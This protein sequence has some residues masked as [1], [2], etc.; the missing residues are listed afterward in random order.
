MAGLSAGRVLSDFFDHVTVVD[1]DAYPEGALERPGVPQSRHVHALLARG[2]QELDGLFPGFSEAMRAGGAH[3]LD[4]PSAFATL[5]PTGWAPRA[6]NRLP[7]FFASRTQIETTVR[8]LFRKLPNVTLLERTAV[9]GL[10]ATRQGHTKATG[11]HITPLDGGVSTT[12]ETDLIVDASGRASKAP[13]WF[14]ELGLTPP[15]ETI[16]DSF[17]GYSSRW[18]KAPDPSRL[19]R[20]WWW[21]GVWIDVKLP[22]NTFACVLIPVEQGRWLVTIAGVAK[23]YPPND[24]AGF[25]ATLPQLRSPIIDKMVQ[26]AEPISPVYS[27]RAMANRFRHYERWQER[28]D[29]FLALGD[30]ACAF[31]PVYGQGMTT[32]AVSATI[33]RDC[34]KQS[35]PTSPELSQQFFRAQAKFQQIPWGLATGA[36]FR[37]PGTEG[38]PSRISSLMGPYMETLFQAG[39]EDPVVRIQVSRVLNMLK[40]PTALFAP[41]IVARVAWWAAKHKFSGKGAG[42]YSAPAMPPVLAS[43]R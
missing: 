24:E 29:G 28:L 15:E 40:L 16:V 27:Y 23:H 38:Q 32:G 43:V 11:V 3:E 30:S 5:R 36:D 4:F 1:R 8:G 2:R 13:E 9:T 10:A 31:N 19:P 25:M 33:L 41:H 21:K 42:G 20:D 14:R 18:F 35:G 22:E 12:L 39:D 17:S 37:F 26:F 6:D 34:L 7:L